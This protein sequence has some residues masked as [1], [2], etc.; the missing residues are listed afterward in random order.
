MLSH[1]FFVYRTVSQ[2]TWHSQSKFFK[3][4]VILKQSF[5]NIY[6]FQPPLQF[7]VGM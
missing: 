7:V 5:Q 6:K 3:F 4:Y 2:C 1:P